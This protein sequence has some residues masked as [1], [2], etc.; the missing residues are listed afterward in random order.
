ML[1]E[2]VMVST[3]AIHVLEALILMNQYSRGWISLPLPAC[4]QF[5][6]ARP[7]SQQN[8]ASLFIPKATWKFILCYNEA[9]SEKI[10]KECWL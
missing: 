9:Q 2:S 4:A 1:W 3:S 6:L 10:E 5:N 8:S 7:Q